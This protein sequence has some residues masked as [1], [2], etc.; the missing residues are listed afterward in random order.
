MKSA[1]INPCAPAHLGDPMRLHLATLAQAAFSALSF[2]VLLAACGGGG[3][4]SETAGGIGSGGTGN[5]PSSGVA[6]GTVGGFGSIFVGGVRCD[7]ALAKVAVNTTT[8]TAETG[9]PDIKLGQSVLITT[10]PASSTCKVLTALVDPEVVG[11]VTSLAPLTVAGQRVLL[12]TDASVAPAT[13]LDGYADASGIKVGDRVEVHGK[14]VTNAGAPAVLASRIERKPGTDTWVRAKGVVAGLTATQFT[15]GGLTV[16]IDGTTRLD[17]ASLSLSNGQTV[18]VWSNAAVAV[19]GS[20]TASAIKLANIN[21][22]DKQGVRVEGPVAGCTAAPCTLPKIDGLTVDLSG[23]TFVTGSQADV[24]NGVAMRVEGSYD[25]TTQRL[26]ATKAGVRL[27]DATAG[28]VTLI[29]MVSDYVSATDFTVRG[30]PV[31]TNG[32]TAVAGGCTIAAGSIVAITGTLSGSQVTAETVACPSLADGLTLDVFG[33][34]VSVD[35]TAKTF[36]LSEGA[37]RNFTFTWDDNTVFGSG[38]TGAT[39]ASG[40]RVG[41]RAVVLDTANRKLL[42]KRVVAD[43]TPN[44]PAGA[45]QL[46]GNFG[47]AHDVN[48]TNGVGS[49]TVN[50]IQMA[51]QA[52]SVVDSGI[53][54]GTQVRTWFY[55]TGPLQPWIALQVSKMAWN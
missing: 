4:G 46:F 36:T 34:L 33:A 16:K 32:S 7:D 40:L 14:A 17:P 47:I 22:V 1:D 48:I 51:V 26:V 20:V 35:T 50:R 42:V 5:S 19:D 43:P 15:I 38:L 53:V 13:V 29:G 18:V 41:L 3:G 54:D 25:A 23:A 10:D 30:V 27:R 44:L 31:T 6:S 28:K 11:V 24:A 55:R 37:Y 2:A 52:T 8:G 12:N 9:T 45:T 49:L 21:L 39:L